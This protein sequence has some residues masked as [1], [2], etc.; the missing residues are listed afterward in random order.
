MGLVEGWARF[1]WP[2]N[3][4]PERCISSSVNG[5]G[6]A[7]L[8]ETR[9]SRRVD[10]LVSGVASIAGSNAEHRLIIEKSLQ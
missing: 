5:K 8:R 6:C 7:S 3:T 1:T 2:T 10:D 9:A 4:S